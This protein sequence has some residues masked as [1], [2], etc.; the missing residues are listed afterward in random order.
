MS[1]GQPLKRM[2][3]IRVILKDKYFE[4]FSSRKK[5]TEVGEFEIGTNEEL[6]RIFG[7]TDITTVVE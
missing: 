6:R 4:Q 2:R 1:P 5:T 7:E 3:T